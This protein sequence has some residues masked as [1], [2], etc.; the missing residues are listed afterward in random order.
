[1][2]LQWTFVVGNPTFVPGEDTA[3]RTVDSGLG[4]AR[5]YQLGKVFVADSHVVD[6]AEIIG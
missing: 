2:S 3:P 1:M 5:F 4:A 6:V